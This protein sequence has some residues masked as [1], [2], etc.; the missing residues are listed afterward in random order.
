MQ[1]DQTETL[2]RVFSYEALAEA[3]SQVEAKKRM[4]QLKI[5]NGLDFYRPHHKQHEF[6]IAD[7]KFRYLRTGNRFGKSDCGAA[8][9]IAWARGER[10]WY[11]YEFD[12]IDGKGKVTYHHTGGEDHPYVRVG[13]PLRS[14]KGLIIVADW[15]KAEEIFTNLDAGQGK[16]KLFKLLPDGCWRYEKDRGEIKKIIVDCVHGGESTIYIDTIKSFMTNKIGQE[17]GDWDWIHVDEPCSKDQWTANSRGL[18]DRKGRGWFTCTPLSEMWINDEF[19]DPKEIRYNGHEPKVKIDPETGKPIYWMLPGS[20]F[21]NPHISAEE[22][23]TIFAGLSENDKKTRIGGLPKA[24]TGV[25][26][27]NFDPEKHIL[28][29]VP[30]GWT[31]ILSPPDNACIRIAIDP[32]P[33]T[34]HAVLFAA[35]MP[36]GQTIFWGEIFQHC[37]MRELAHMIK[38]YIGNRP[39]MRC[40]VDPS[41]WIEDAVDGSSMA[42]DLFSHAPFLPIEKASKDL[43]RGILRTQ[44]ALSQR[45]E[46]GNPFLLFHETLFRTLLE[47]DRYV[48]DPKK[49]KPQDKD[50][51]T[52][53]CLYRLV[54]CSTALESANPGVFQYIDPNFTEVAQPK[55]SPLD[56]FSLDLP[57]FQEA[58]MPSIREILHEGAKQINHFGETRYRRG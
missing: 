4:E 55:S 16:G 3:R 40:V 15:D 18:I 17:S 49:E 35:T 57:M 27:T 2:E 41:A 31:S 33:K 23:K 43:S 44:M 11:K 45:N 58:R 29:D 13:L 12:V 39:V 38:E 14:T 37:M 53:E 34:P 51:H 19:L 21:D 9:D 25:I 50:D 5:S 46:R 52:M 32:H 54:M 47:F 20:S 24:L 26:Y 36:N 42:V 22:V 10:T 30:K 48:W 28:R 7:Y 8:E 6:H 1:I 56:N